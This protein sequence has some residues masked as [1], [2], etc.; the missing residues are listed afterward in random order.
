MKRNFADTL[1]QVIK[2]ELGAHVVPGSHSV[3]TLQHGANMQRKAF[4]LL[5]GGMDSTTCLYKAIYDFAPD[6][7]TADKHLNGTRLTLNR[8]KIDWVEAVSINYGQRHTK[9]LEYAAS[10]CARL[11]IRH[12]ILDVGNLLSGKTVM[13]TNESVGTVDVPD[14]DYA[15]IKGV[16]PTYVPFRNGLMLSALTAHAQK[17]VNEQIQARSKQLG[18]GQG[19]SMHGTNVATQE[20]ANLCGIYFG[21]HS[22]DAANWAYPDCT[23]EFIGAMANAIYIGSYM[24]IRLHT[25]IQW[26]MKHEIVTLGDK[27]GVPFETTW[28]CYKGEEHHCGT[29]PTCRSR[30]QAFEIAGVKDPTEYGNMIHAQG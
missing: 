5:S 14:I 8:Q 7:A 22:E 25:P 30:R 19:A 27:L 2:H 23:P 17:Y 3:P 12:T 20:A 24:S 16:S 13:L 4:V 29:C 15:D 9:E 18:E 6:D 28:S 11:G 26:L 21:A 10:T 1:T